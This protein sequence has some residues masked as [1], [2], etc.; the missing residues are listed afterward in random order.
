MNKHQL[1]PILGEY[2]STRKEYKANSKRLYQFLGLI[3]LILLGILLV[4]TVQLDQIQLEGNSTF[5]IVYAIIMGIFFLSPLIEKTVYRNSIMSGN[6][7]NI[8]IALK[9][10]PY[11]MDIN[12][13]GE[14]ESFLDKVRGFKWELP[15]KVKI[16]IHFTIASGSFIFGFMSNYVLE[17]MI[18]MHGLIDMLGIIILNYSAIIIIILALYFVNWVFYTQISGAL[19]WIAPNYYVRKKILIPDLKFYLK[20]HKFFA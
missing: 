3:C 15:K 17:S 5:F 11:E 9:A 14:V 16:L 10:I 4:L 12:C 7:E 19:F 8:A 1:Y 18:E 6:L 20:N 2:N 13:Y